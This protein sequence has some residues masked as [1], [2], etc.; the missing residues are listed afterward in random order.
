M[1]GPFGTTG[2]SLSFSGHRSKR[3]IDCDP[4][5]MVAKPCTWRN[6]YGFPDLDVFST[7]FDTITSSCL[8]LL[9]AS[10]NSL[11]ALSCLGAL[12]YHNDFS[13]A[14][15]MSTTNRTVIK[16]HPEIGY[17]LKAIAALKGVTMVALIAELVERETALHTTAL[18]DLWIEKNMGTHKPRRPKTPAPHR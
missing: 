17:R 9:I 6:L 2:N 7:G 11:T 1:Q 15:T 16:L 13:G 8:M 18:R 4:S 5:S 12:L 3:N 10:P 14:N